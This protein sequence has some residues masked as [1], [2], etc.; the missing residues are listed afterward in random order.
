MTNQLT[1]VSFAPTLDVPD[2]APVL[3]VDVANPGLTFDDLL[4]ANFISMEGLEQWLDERNA[5]ARVLTVTGVSMELLYDPAREKPADGEWKPCLSFAETDSKL[6]INKTRA[7]QLK[8][9]TGSPLVAACIGLTIAIRPGIGN[10]KAQV[11]I[12]GVPNSAESTRRS[13]PTNGRRPA[14]VD[15]INSELFG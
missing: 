3:T 7:A 12:E 5:A 4:P 13:K 10:G 15:D 8:R 9:L 1:T 14:D 6:V 2:T 11:V